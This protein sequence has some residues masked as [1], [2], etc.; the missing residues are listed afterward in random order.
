MLVQS[1]Y[2]WK[3]SGSFVLK[4]D[5]TSSAIR[6]ISSEFPVRIAGLFAISEKIKMGKKN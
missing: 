3:K 5:L 1:K 4:I 6:A 2:K